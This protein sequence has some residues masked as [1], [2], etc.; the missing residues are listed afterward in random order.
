MTGHECLF[1]Y[2]LHSSGSAADS[3]PGVKH[4]L[5][6]TYS[7]FSGVAARQAPCERE[8]GKEAD[9]VSRWFKGIF[10]SFSAEQTAAVWVSEA[11]T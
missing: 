1:S 5:H 11:L 4:S 2:Q 6:L 3:E 7:H 8:G 9:S 10:C